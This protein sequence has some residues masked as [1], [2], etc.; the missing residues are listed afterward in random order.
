MNEENNVKRV[1]L[2]MVIAVA[3]LV[4]VVVGATYAYF[5][6]TSTNNFGT[7]TATATAASVGTVTFS[8]GNNLSMSLS[9]AQMMKGANDITYYAQQGANQAATTT[10]TTV[11]I[12]SVTASAGTFSCDY[13]IGVTATGTNNMYTAFQGMTGK[14]TGQI[15][16]TVTPFGGTATTLDFNTADLFTNKTISGSVTGVTTTAKNLTAQLKFINKK[17]VDQSALK[18][19]DITIS[20]T[21]SAFTCTATA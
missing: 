16:L 5:T 14:S 11:T 6:V 17:D 1:I 4:I 15:V 19:T 20:F 12:G 21:V 8:T 2:P 13:T 9:A 3:T 10:A 7:R 18:N